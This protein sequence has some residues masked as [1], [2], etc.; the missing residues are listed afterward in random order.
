MFDSRLTTNANLNR[1]NG[2]GVAFLTRRRRTPGL[3][4]ERLAA[5][6]GY[7]RQ[8]TL[9]NVG[10]I[11]RKPRIRDQTITLKP[12]SGELRQI[13]I[14]D[15]GHEKPT[16]L[17]TNQMDVPAHRLVDRYARRMVIENTIA[18]AIDFFHMD[19]LV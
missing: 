3:I 14:T 19:A 10:R 8:I 13:T 11:Y 18:D 9:T 2:L 6:A 5:P 16:L 17:I 15:L 7:W 12:C 1:L 4:A